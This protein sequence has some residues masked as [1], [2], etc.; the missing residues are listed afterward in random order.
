MHDLLHNIKIQQALDPVVATATKTSAA[1]DLK[2]YGCAAVIFSVGNSGDT[3]SGSVKWTLKLT[4]S[5]DNTT[6]TDVGVA[7]MHND[8]ATVV[9][10]APAEDTL[11]VSFGYKGGKRYLKAVA[12]ATGTHTNGTPMAMLAVLGHAAQ[13][14]VA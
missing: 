1:I 2:G 9:I 3:L 4:E 12:T 10:D 11:A 13:A 8:A 6:Y 5:D 14:P 7:D